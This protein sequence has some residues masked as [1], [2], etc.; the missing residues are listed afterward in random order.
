ML[1]AA[2]CHTVYVDGSFVTEKAV[3]ADYDACWE[4]EGVDH[5]RLDPI[6]I[7]FRYNRISQKVK[8]MGELFPV[9]SPVGDVGKQML[10][11]FQTD[12]NGNPKGIVAF[13]LRRMR[14]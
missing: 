14:L 4:L 5:N 10:N 8:Y 6:L 7:D 11:F 9:H 3:P 2:G 12:K 13:N 1:F